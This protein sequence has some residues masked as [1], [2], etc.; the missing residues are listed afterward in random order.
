MKLFI[1][2]SDRV[3]GVARQTSHLTRCATS[4]DAFSQFKI[5]FPLSDDDVR[6]LLE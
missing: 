5:H 1:N 4:T 3:Y 2:N 6:I